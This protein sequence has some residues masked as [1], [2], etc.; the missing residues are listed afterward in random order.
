MSLLDN[1]SQSLSAEKQ[2]ERAFQ[3]EAELQ[4]AREEISALKASVSQ[5]TEELNRLKEQLALAQH[6]R[7]GKK[8]ELGEPISAGEPSTLTHISAHARKKKTKGRLIDLS[9]LPRWTVYHDLPDGEK[10]CTCCQQPLRHIGKDISEQVEVLPQRLYVQEHVRYKYACAHCKTIC[11]S[12]KDKAP[13]P[14]AL[15]GASL[16]TEVIINKYQYHL[17]LYRQSKILASFHAIIPDNTLGNW[18]MTVGNALM[19]IYEAL[20]EAVLTAR[21]LQVDETPIKILN[22]EKKGYLWC[23][24][25][26]HEGAGLVIFEISLT[27]GGHVAEERLASYEGLL[28]TDGYPGYTKLRKRENIEGFGCLT[29]ARRSFDEVLKISKNKEGIAAEAIERLKPLYALEA[30]MRDKKYNFKIRKRL[31]QKIARPILQDFYRWLKKMAP[32]VPPKSQ[33]GLAIQYT[34]NQW[35]YLIKYLRHGMAEI[36]TNWV[37]N[38][39]RDIAIGKKNWLFMGNKDSGVVHALFYSLVL[40]CIANRLNPRLYLHFLIVQIHNIRQGKID[41]RQLLP[42]TIDHGLL[43]TFAEEQL[44]VARAV[45]NTT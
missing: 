10:I 35:P 3:L 1:A 19:K 9:L 34:F 15:A 11:M 4:M 12:P 2:L 26:P 44:D 38:K 31:R 28:Q 33:L 29:H 16:L 32:Q 14:K 5:L 20:W 24:Y 42:H 6:R 17:P 40:S 39:I 21:Y 7:F 41:P 18:V 25:A 45:L 43:K 8:S 23:Y 37:E 30:N 27:R 22:P 36:D 13:I